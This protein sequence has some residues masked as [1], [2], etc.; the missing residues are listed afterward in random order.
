LAEC[1]ERWGLVPDGSFSLSYRYVEPVRTA[2]G[3]QAVLKLGPPEQPEYRQEV[4]AAPRSPPPP[5]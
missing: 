4:A 3:Q 2:D 5:G 1:R